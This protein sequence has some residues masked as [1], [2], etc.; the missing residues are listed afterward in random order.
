MQETSV[1]KLNFNKRLYNLSSIK[2]AIKDFQIVSDGSI[3]E[4]KDYIHVILVLKD[5]S[6]QSNIGHEFANYILALMKNESIV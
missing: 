3:N 5:E 1:I 2:Q 4:S 6:L